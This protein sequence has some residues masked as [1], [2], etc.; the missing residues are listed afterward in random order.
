MMKATI[1][2]HDARAEYWFEEGCYI[3][4]LSNR[5]E[6][7]AVSVARLRVPPRGTTRLHSLTGIVERYVLLQGRARVRVGTLDETVGPGDVVIIP[8]GESQRITNL[9]DQD[10]LFLAIC[11]PRFERAAYSDLTGPDG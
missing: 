9:E 4:E 7:R 5:S 10:L 3:N 6:D 11:T 8:V 1:L 2:R